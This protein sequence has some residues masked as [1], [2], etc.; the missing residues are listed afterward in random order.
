[1]HGTP[2]KGDMDC[3]E[4]KS[5]VLTWFGNEI[6]CRSSGDDSLIV[7][8]P[9]LRLNGDAIDVGIS[10]GDNGGWRLSDLGETHSNFFLGNL[11]F[12]DDYV[13]AEEF[14]QILVAHNLKDVDQEILMEVNANDVAAS[15]FDFLSSLQAMSGLQL[16]AKP[17]KEKRDFNLIVA[18]FFAEQGASVEVPPDAIEG[19][20]G[21]WKFDFSLNH[22]RKETLIKTI[23]TVGKNQ[24]VG[25]TEKA[26]FEIGDVKKFRDSDA[27]VIGDDHGQERE[28]LW[29]P[30]VLRIFNEYNVPF[31]AFEKDND[32]LVDL[33]QQYSATGT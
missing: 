28:N 21:R 30:E 13:R 26:T 20:S 19:I 8:F 12:Q 3:E 4:I 17:R 9:V 23:S 18:L 29:R 27:I 33:A 14:N 31:Y 5:R 6:E 10:P 1:Y 2:G 24:I 25:L 16:T 11:D 7:T 22:V 32:S 15:V